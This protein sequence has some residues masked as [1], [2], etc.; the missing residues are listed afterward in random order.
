MFGFDGCS[1]PPE[2]PDVFAF[3]LA[4][5]PIGRQ[6]HEYHVAPSGTAITWPYLF[7]SD[8]FCNNLIIFPCHN[9][10]VHLGGTKQEPFP[11]PCHLV[12]RSPRHIPTAVAEALRQYLEMMSAM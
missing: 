8:S 6:R 11:F 1:S 12:V 9:Y 3:V 7:A 10:S 5:I 2:A 4:R